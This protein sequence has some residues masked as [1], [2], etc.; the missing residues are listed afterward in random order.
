MSP[1]SGDFSYKR[2]L[3]EAPRGTPLSP[4]TLARWGLTTNHAGK[5]ARQGW[6]DRL[7][8]GVYLVKGDQLTRDGAL[9]FLAAQVPGFHVGGKTALAWRGV[10]HNL[11]AR[12]TLSLWGA[13]WNRLPAWFTERFPSQY[14]SSSLFAE[15]P[16]RL[17]GV[18]PLPHGSAS[19]PVSVPERAVLELLS[20]VGRRQ[21]IDEARN[22]VENLRG[23]RE[24]VLADLLKHTERLKV[25]R[26]LSKLA[27][28]AGH[29]WVH[30]AAERSKALGGAARIVL[31]LPDGGY[32]D[33]KP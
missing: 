31:H 33:L 20:N 24:S 21:S 25:V 11:A 32:L 14:Q 2:L 1:N 18:G 3:A 9:A 5:L 26:L 4:S 30:V 12:E 10:Q 17:L 15:K 27:R 22:L 8:Q 7:G 19:V 28:D 29:P 13:Q 23:L 16:N 6:L